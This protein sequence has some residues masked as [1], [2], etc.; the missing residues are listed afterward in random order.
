MPLIPFSSPA[1]HYGRGS[2]KALRNIKGKKVLIVTDKILMELGIVDKAIKQLKKS[3]EPMEYRVFDEIEPDPSD[4]TIMKGVNIAKE[5]EPDWFIG[6][7]GGSSLDAAKI[8]WILY[9]RQDLQIHEILPMKFLDLRKKAKIITIPTTSGT[10]SEVTWA[11][12]ITDSKNKKKL[13]LGNAE[14]IADIA[15]V[16][17]SLTMTMPPKVTAF[18]GMDALTHAIEGYVSTLKND[19]SDGL[20]LKAI[21][22]IFENLPIAFKNG[23]DKKAR[24]NMHNAATIAG[25]GFGNSQAALAHGAGHSIGAQLS[26]PHGVC[27]GVMLPYVIEFCQQTSEEHYQEIINYIGLEKEGSA[28]KTLSRKVKKLLKELN[29]PTAIKDIVTKEKFDEKFSKIVELTLMDPSSSTSPR[30]INEETTKAI[31]LAAF[32]GTD[33]SI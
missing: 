9:E 18:T 3:K 28:A 26:I 33:V 27:V 22:L 13:S 20:C 19:Y 10:G 6:L 30:V 17:P 25:I 29:L 8:I 12:V 21:K 24:E 14:A 2:L 11:M 1:I 5:F 32:E 4:T 31:L 15:I 7:G 23:E 16:D